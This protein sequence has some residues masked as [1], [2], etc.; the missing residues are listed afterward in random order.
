MPDIRGFI[1]IGVDRDVES[2]FVD[3]ELSGQ[4]FP[5]VGDRLFFEVV[6]EREVAEHFEKGVVP[7]GTTDVFQVIVLAAGTHALLR[8]GGP[9]VIA[10]F[11]TKKAVLEL[12]HPGIG[13]EQGRVVVRH[14]GRRADNRVAAVFK[15]FQKQ[16][17]YFTT[18]LH[19]LLQYLSVSVDPGCG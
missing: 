16:L 2:G 11:R 15:I 18:G 19:C 1:V 5:C 10:F 8:G 12:V 6:A 17:A 9:D 14:E 7:G 4:E 13:K 3:A